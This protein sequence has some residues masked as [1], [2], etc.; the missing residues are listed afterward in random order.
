MKLRENLSFLYWGEMM[1]II[2]VGMPYSGK[3]TLAKRL[4]RH[5]QIPFID[6]DQWIEQ[7]VGCQVSDIFADLGEALFREYEFQALE[8]I[9]KRGDC[10]VATGG[11]MLTTAKNRQKL[12]ELGATIVYLDVPIL[13]LEARAARKNGAVRPLLQTQTIRQLFIKRKQ[14][15]ARLA[16]IRIDCHQKNA[17]QITAE[18]IQ[19][20]TR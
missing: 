8:M 9:D 5:F 18:I 10:V 11:G 3:S 20:V 1:K 2:L 14:D 13:L 7:Q 4:A 12:R 17:N 19:H 16:E 15:Y 6:T